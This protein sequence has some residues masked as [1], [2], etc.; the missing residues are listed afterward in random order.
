METNERYVYPY[1]KLSETAR[2]I[3]REQLPDVVRARIWCPINLNWILKR[4]EHSDFYIQD[5]CAQNSILFLIDGTMI[6]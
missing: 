2:K 1:Y 3:A 5:W 4:T 6:L